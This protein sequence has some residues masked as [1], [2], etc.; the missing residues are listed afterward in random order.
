MNSRPLLHLISVALA[1]CSAC[2]PGVG[3]GGESNIRPFVIDLFVEDNP[4]GPS[5][6]PNI[7]N[8]AELRADYTFVNYRSDVPM[9]L[10][11]DGRVYSWD[12]RDIRDPYFPFSETITPYLGTAESYTAGIDGSFGAFYAHQ[13]DAVRWGPQDYELEAFATGCEMAGL[14]CVFVNR[15]EAHY[16]FTVQPYIS[17]H[18]CCAP[19]TALVKVEP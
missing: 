10:F 8:Y 11:V 19:A 1:C 18:E 6:P 12:E 13:I 7:E 5:H 17:T 9:R 3:G 2:V 16:T 15:P 14:E 4:I